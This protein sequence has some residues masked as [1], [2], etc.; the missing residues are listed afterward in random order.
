MT[1][2]IL[3]DIEK[4]N[5]ASLMK[6]RIITYYIHNVNSTITDL[7]K[8]L[9]L[10]VPTVT[11]IIDEMCASGYLNIYG[12]LETNGG[13][14]P[15]LY[16]LNPA[17]GYF[18]GVEVKRESVNIGVIN[19]NGELV[20]KRMDIPYRCENTY[21][22]LDRLCELI[23]EH[24]ASSGIE[25]RSVLNVHISLSGR[26]NSVTGYSY[27]YFNLS[28]QPLTEVLSKKLGLRVSV[29]N[30]TR[31]MAY[32]E[33]LRGIVGSEK[34][35]LFINLSWGLGLGIIINGKIFTGKSG[36]A[37]EFGHTPVLDNQ[38]IC[39]CGK[40]GCLETEVSGSALIRILKER[41]L[42]GESSIVSEMVNG[43]LD[44]LVLNDVVK[45]VNNEDT[46][47][48]DIVESIGYKLGKQLASLINIF[49]P[50]LVIIGG[51]LS[52]IADYIIEPVKT[53]IRKHSLNMINN[54][55]VITISKL[56][57][58]AGI[59]GACMLARSRVFEI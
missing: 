4:G 32:G 18:V 11:K 46:L 53:S 56:K 45:A 26:V 8:E 52:L 17:G 40:K 30:D 5:K 22:A 7:T 47:C 10:S 14:H 35:V 1:H 34:N 33:Y 19:F 28:E 23:N 58:Q 55:S 2:E 12:K 43:N 44:N 54:D 6:R 15:N 3:R 36:F 51:T 20:D 38:L 27:S 29:D 42:S 50:E 16:G 24:I 9:D 37:G 21:E 39:R 41:I 31:A 25:P 49:N 48:I 59:V 57:N 13:R